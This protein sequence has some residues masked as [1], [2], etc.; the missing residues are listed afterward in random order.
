MTMNPSDL[1]L[2]EAASSIRAGSLSPL[3]YILCLFA[4]IDQIE[5][6]IQAWTTIDRDAVLSEASR[7]EDEARSKQ[8]RGPLHGVPVGI[9]DIFYTRG[10]RT[11][12][13]SDL[14][15]DYIPKHDAR[16]VAKLK[17]A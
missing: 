10:L 14:F 4:R 16:V 17:Q 8:F 13:G 6:R 7:C 9:K 5:S 11:T 2:I 3:D 12:M 15:K 1:S